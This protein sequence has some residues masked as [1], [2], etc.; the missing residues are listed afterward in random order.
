MDIGLAQHAGQL[1]PGSEGGKRNAQ[2][3]DP[4]HREPRHRPGGPV[5]VEQRQPRSLSY[6]GSQE[7]A[8]QFRAS[9]IGFPEGE[10]EV[11][12]DHERFGTIVGALAKRLGHA[13]GK[14]P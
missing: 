7:P 3:A 12:A 9:G 6:A 10:A 2:G 13:C 8:G 4:G 11:G 5:R 1:G 14:I